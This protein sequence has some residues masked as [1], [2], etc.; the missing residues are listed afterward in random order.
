M[1]FDGDR[2]KVVDSSSPVS[3]AGANDIAYLVSQ[4]PADPPCRDEELVRC[5]LEQSWGPRW[6]IRSTRP[7]GTTGL[8]SPT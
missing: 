3:G 8:P 6:T 5:Y 2:L 4:G 7:G 1:F